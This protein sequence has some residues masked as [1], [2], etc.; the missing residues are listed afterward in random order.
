MN[1]MNNKT[2]K[3]VMV[4]AAALLVALQASARELSY[5]YVDAG[6]NT[7]EIDSEDFTGYD[8][9]VVWA[10]NSDLYFVGQTSALE[11]DGS[12]VDDVELDAW[13][14]GAGVRIPLQDALHLVTEFGYIQRDEFDDGDVNDENGFGLNA[15][16]RGI[17]GR[18]EW[19][20]EL[21]IG[22]IDESYETAI[23]AV[24]RY[25]VLEAVAVGLGYEWHDSDRDVIRAN[26][27]V[28]F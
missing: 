4:A 13:F 3:T 5:N 28:N 1:P 7:A 2:L 12:D 11:G 24:G 9:E 6:Y 19:D 25:Y 20:A 10:V 21:S 26:L 18:F 15:G 17:E 23:R 16:L 27:R 8:F 14:L 22:S